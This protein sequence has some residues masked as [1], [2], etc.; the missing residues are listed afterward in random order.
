[1]PTR[2]TA[3]I[4][5]RLRT[6]LEDLIDQAAEPST[7]R[8]ASFVSSTAVEHAKALIEPAQRLSLGRTDAEAFLTALDRPV[9]CGDH[10]GRLIRKIEQKAKPAARKK[11]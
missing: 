10:L 7:Q 6:D 5:L 4:K 3:R 8:P 1:M 9:N 2:A 11:R